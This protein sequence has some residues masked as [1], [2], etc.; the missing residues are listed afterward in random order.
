MSGGEDLDTALVE[1]LVEI[2]GKEKNIYEKILKLSMD[3]KDVIVAGNVSELEGITR[4]EQS[5]L[6]K[7]GKLEGEREELTGELAAALKI[8]PS[9]VT[10]SGLAKMVPD[11]QGARLRNCRDS[12]LKTI[13]DI[14]S[15][16]TLN[17]KLIR[18]SLDY[19]DFSINILSNAGAT[20]NNYS[21]SGQSND[22]KKRNFF[23][24]KL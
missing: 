20:G 22:P 9:E 15:N 1:R 2:L 4:M 5:I 19:I 11:E 8:N 12:F 18:N 10:L 23:D 6:L 14:R 16:N 7:L 21:N 13:D 24:M 3:K 17:S